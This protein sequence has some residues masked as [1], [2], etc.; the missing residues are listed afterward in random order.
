MFFATHH[1]ML[2]MLLCMLSLAAP[3]L[4]MYRAMSASMALSFA[5]SALHAS[6]A[7]PGGQS[8]TQYSYQ[9]ES[10]TITAQLLALS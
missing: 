8:Y 7:A 9:S 4:F 6:A 5:C 10:K 3:P 1:I 2:G